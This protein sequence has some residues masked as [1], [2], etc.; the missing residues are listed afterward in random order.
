MCRRASL[1]QQRTILE[2]QGHRVRPSDR[3]ASGRN[4]GHGQICHI[5]Q[6]RTG[7]LD[8]SSRVVVWLH[9]RLRWPSNGRNA[10]R[11]SHVRARFL[12]IPPPRTRPALHGPSEE[13]V[14]LGG[15]TSANVRSAWGTIHVTSPS[16]RNSPRHTNLYL[17]RPAFFVPS[18]RLGHQSSETASNASNTFR[19]LWSQP[20]FGSPP[21]SRAQGHKGDDD[22]PHT[23]H[24]TTNQQCTRAL[25]TA[26]SAEPSKGPR[27]PPIACSALNTS[28]ELLRPDRNSEPSMGQSRQEVA[29]TGDRHG[30]ANGCSA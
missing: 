6:R 18:L 14:V 19:A 2:V 27:A 1:F 26:A 3:S 11:T 12:R 23:I 29:H 10:S 30:S 20:A 9:Q 5:R 13:R 22:A 28:R 16:C 7:P 8:C 25:N 4:R 17:C 21:L 15:R 24:V